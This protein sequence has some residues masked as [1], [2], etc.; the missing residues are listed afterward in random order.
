[1]NSTAKLCT[2]Q[3]SANPPEIKVER[4]LL[5]ASLE[6]FRKQIAAVCEHQGAVFNALQELLPQLV[7]AKLENEL[8]YRA[9]TAQLNLLQQLSAPKKSKLTDISL[10][11]WLAEELPNIVRLSKGLLDDYF[12]DVPRSFSDIETAR[13]RL[14]TALNIRAAESQR[15]W[16]WNDNVSF[17][18]STIPAFVWNLAGIWRYVLLV[19]Q[20]RALVLRRCQACLSKEMAA[21]CD[22]LIR[23]A[24]RAALDWLSDVQWQAEQRVAERT[25]TR[26]VSGEIVKLLQER[27]RGSNVQRQS[28]P[29]DRYVSKPLAARLGYADQLL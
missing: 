11:I 16:T 12:E 5:E 18:M 1:M 6:T 9:R 29:A 26:I 3:Q 19:P 21:Y 25:D 22:R 17:A 7:A 20:L 13:R 23:L 2:P 15:E 10:A 8:I 4:D 14:F 27:W 28:L 24:R